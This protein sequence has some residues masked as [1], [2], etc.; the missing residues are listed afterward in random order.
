MAPLRIAVMGAGGVGGYFGARL[1]AAGHDVVFIARGRHLAAM[2]TSGLRI[3][4]PVGD[5]HL[6]PTSAVA[7]PHEVGRADVIMFAVK[8]ADTD[9]A[10]QALK[11]LVAAGA[12]VFTFQNGV[13]SAD[14]LAAVLGADAVVPG[15]ARIASH[16][17]KPG[18]IT[19]T[20]TFAR[21]EFGEASGQASARTKAF[22]EACTASGIDAISPDNIT[23]N[24]WMKF[25]LLAPF[26]GLT[27]LI[28]SPI[29][30]IRD[31]ARAS[32]LLRKAVEEVV[33]VGTALGKGLSAAD[34]ERTLKAIASL[35]YEMTSSMA[36][37]LAAGKPLEI[38]G[39][40]GAVVRLGSSCGVAAPTHGFIADCLGVHAAGKQAS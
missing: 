37:D 14:R 15:V 6:A 30:P 29:G 25:A 36:H 21:L 40:S 7:E 8:M 34:V 10:A 16:I 28:R 4:S 22:L 39:L 1:A 5:L 20:G 3:E 23:R 19:Q 33:A 12:A 17:S 18:V 38:N 9:T 32:A 24:I 27:S 35:P 13:E 26:S 2:Q 31:D 11:P